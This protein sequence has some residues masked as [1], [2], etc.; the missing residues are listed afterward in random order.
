MQIPYQLRHQG[1]PWILEW[2]QSLS[3]VRLFV[4]PWTAAH[5]ASLSITNSQL[6][7]WVAYPF[8]SRSSQP[9]NW[10]ESPALQADSL[11]TGLSGKLKGNKTE[12]PGLTFF[13][14]FFILFIVNERASQVVLAVENPPAKAGR[15]KRHRLDPWTGKIA[16]RRAQQPTPVLLPGESH[17][18]RS[19]A[20]CNL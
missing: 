19:L 3:R 18:Q 12:Q 8:S 10:P 14:L 17:G 11:P 4:T 7:G 5:Q 9:R 20:G 16:W 15:R 13:T 2:V 6:L 1:S